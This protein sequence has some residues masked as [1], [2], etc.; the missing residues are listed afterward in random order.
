MDEWLQQLQASLD[1]AAQDSGKWLVEV[2]E[3]TDQ[4]VSNAVDE[5]AEAISPVVIEINQ[6]VEDSLDATE[7][8]IYQRLTPWMEEAT[9]PITNTITPYLQEHH[10]CVGCKYYNG[11]T[12]GGNMLVCA[13][14]PYGPEDET[15]Q[16]WSSVWTAKS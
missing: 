1:E 11:S 13:M 3:E 9:A 12:H 2:I 7:M 16:D 5:M 6:Q 10:A 15:C 4:A 8:F 14:H